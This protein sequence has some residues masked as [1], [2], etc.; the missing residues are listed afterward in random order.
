M[1]WHKNYLVR[2]LTAAAGLERE[3]LPAPGAEGLLAVYD[4]QT[5][6]FAESP[7]RLL[8]LI[9]LLWR[10]WLSWFSFR[11]APAQTFQRFEQIYALLANGTTF[12][13]PV[14]LLKA[15]GLYD[16]TQASMFEW[17][18]VNL[19]ESGDLLGSELIAGVNRC[20]CNQNNQEL[21]A[22]AGMVSMPARHRPWSLP[23]VQLA[24][25]QKPV[26]PA[27]KYQQTVATF[28]RGEVRPSFF[29]LPSMDYAAVLV[30]DAAAR[31]PWSSLGLE[32]QQPCVE[33]VPHAWLSMMFEAGFEVVANHTWSTPGA[34][35][36][37]DPPEDFAPFTL[38]PG[39]Y[40][41]AA[42]ENAASA[43]EIAAIEGRMAA[44]LTAQHLRRR[45]A[46]DAGEQAA[47]HLRSEGVL[48]AGTGAGSERHEAAGAA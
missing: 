3:D 39:L 10:Y 25:F 5:L 15:V 42:L 43:M 6:V 4:G 40:Y 21:N 16:L 36:A 29:G 34:Y 38:C 14:D 24:G 23:G 37:F 46:A 11:G 22:L 19:G 48:G 41:A 28:V 18:R 35:P 12:D 8:T 30:S 17:L 47:L 9:R 1:V 13:R 31:L 44:L 33:A 32:Q 45:G 2:D 26:V 20:N 27:R 7:W